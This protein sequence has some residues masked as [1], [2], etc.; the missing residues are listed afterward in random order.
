MVLYI[1]Q[2]LDNSWNTLQHHKRCNALALIA[3][4]DLLLLVLLD[5]V[6][7]V[8]S[9]SFCRRT[10]GPIRRAKGGWTPEE[11]CNFYFV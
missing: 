10:T 4:I 9:C 7:C 1:P 3:S 5:R 6:L 8:L 2:I 11:V